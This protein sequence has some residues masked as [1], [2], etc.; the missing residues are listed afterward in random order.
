MSYKT[1]L[2][3]YIEFYL[4]VAVVVAEESVNALD[5]ILSES[6]ILGMQYNKIE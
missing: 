5:R 6:I 2:L 1:I 4:D 3:R